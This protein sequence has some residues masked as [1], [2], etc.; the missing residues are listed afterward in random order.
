MKTIWCGRDCADAG[1]GD[2]ENERLLLVELGVT[3]QRYRW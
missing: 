1:E 3:K 2:V